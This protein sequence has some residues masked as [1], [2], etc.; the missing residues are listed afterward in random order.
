MEIALSKVNLEVGDKIVIRGKVKASHDH[1][2]INSEFKDR[3]WKIKSLNKTKMVLVSGGYGITYV[4]PDYIK[5]VRDYGSG[6][7][8]VYFKDLSDN[9]IKVT[10]RDV[11][12][13]PTFTA[14]RI[15]KHNLSNRY[16]KVLYEG[17][18]TETGE[19][20][21]VYSPIKTYSKINHKDKV[22]IRPKSMFH[23]VLNINGEEKKRFERVDNDE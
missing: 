13:N 2:C 1:S 21:V 16:Y 18:H 22:W 19:E 8:H 20:L 14:K 3:V 12:F 5:N 10:S 6:S 7:I 4:D 17:Q 15:Y 9:K 11:T 23:E